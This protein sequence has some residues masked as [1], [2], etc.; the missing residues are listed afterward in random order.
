MRLKGGKFL[1]DISNVDLTPELVEIPLKKEEVKCILEKGITIK[2]NNPI[3]GFSLV[4]D[5]LPY[6][7]NGDGIEYTTF[8]DEDGVT[9]T[10][11]LVVK[12][13]KLTITHE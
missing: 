10:L 4:Y 3:G 13:N 5:L 12:S 6:I 9:R 2:L 11:Y 7:I 1:L 8:Q